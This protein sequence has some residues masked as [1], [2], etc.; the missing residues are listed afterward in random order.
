VVFAWLAIALCLAGRSATAAFS[1]PAA[2]PQPFVPGEVLIGW[3]PQAGVIPAGA[4]PA[5]WD[6]ERTS[7][8]WQQAA[9]TLATLTG[10]KVLDV[11]PADG[12]A[13]LAVPAGQEAEAIARLER[14]PWV[15]YAELNYLVYVRTPEESTPHPEPLAPQGSSFYPNDPFIG[16]QWNLRRVGAPEAWEV[17]LGSYSLVVALVDSGIDRTHPEFANRLLQGYDYV[18]G[19]SDPSDDFGHG[20]HVAGILAAAANNSIGVAGLAPNVK[21]LPLK[22]LDANGSGTYDNIATAIRR[23]ADSGAQ[24]INL[25]LGGF[26]A[27]STL[28]GAV[29]YAMAH[30]AL[31]VAAAGNCAQGGWA[32][33][34]LVNP[35]YYPAAY[36]GVLA[37]AASDHYDNWASYS[38]YKPYIALA[39]PG[40]T[41]GDQIWSTV[42]G[43]Y[44]FRYGTSMAT[45]LVSAAA[46]LVWTMAPTATYTQVSE[47]L[48]STAEQVG[49][50][51]YVGGRNDYFGYG[52]L[53]AGRAVRRAYP[54]SLRPITETQFFLLG[55]P[56]TQQSIRLAILNPSDQAIWW[57][58][59][60]ITGTSWLSVTP[61]SQSTSYSNPSTL[62]LRAGPTSLPPGSYTGTVRVQALYPPVGSFDIRAQLLITNTVRRSFV[63]LLP[64]R[65][66]RAAWIDPSAGGQPLNLVNNSSRQLLLP[67][68]IP[69]YGRTYSSIWVSDNG[70]AFFGQP[71]ASQYNQNS[72]LPS[73]AVPNDAIYAL[74]QDWNPDLG[75]QV[76]GHQAAEDSYV[77]T[78]YQMRR[79]MWDFPHSF[80]IVLLRDGRIL[81]QYRTLG[82]LTSGTIGIE[83]FDGTVATQIFCNG[84][85]RL[86][87]DGEAISLTAELPW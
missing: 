53:N 69:F 77:I 84:S 68:P 9:R 14:L 7:A 46:S 22:V 76:Y 72:C 70:L 6:E 5:G 43:G 58:A 71:T 82:P 45:A 16:D 30:N 2:L 13:R 80:Q 31:V 67:F 24:V 23:A 48:K 74:W 25:S 34:Y 83:N 64:N 12:T 50:Y 26:A 35:D 21:L 4:R 39:A 32:C 55:G 8:D 18:N 47:I 38:G 11:H 61:T 75:G 10:L 20:T 42:P 62:T 37:V 54:P 87:A 60:V 63:P 15:S 40:G 44:D 19:D 81:L 49:G 33:N 79:N 57:Q 78:W 1:L 73:A 17:T 52:R 28:K 29:D 86:V 3:D 51:P 85:G 27:S 65:V 56:V 66:L 59:S 41:A 36:P